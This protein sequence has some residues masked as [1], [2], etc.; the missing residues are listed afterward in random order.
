MSGVKYY[1]LPF[2]PLIAITKNKISVIKTGFEILTNKYKG[3]IHTYIHTYIHTLIHAQRMV[4]PH[5]L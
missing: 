4:V 5:G 1:I 3:G 2:I